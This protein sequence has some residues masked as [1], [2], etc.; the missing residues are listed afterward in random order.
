[1]VDENFQFDQVFEK[2]KTLFDKEETLLNRKWQYLPI[3][4]KYFKDLELEILSLFDN[5][6]EALNGRLIRSENYQALNT[7]KD[8]YNGTFKVKTCFFCCN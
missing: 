1:M 4:T 5:L 3:D 7:L 6:D 2:E 8:K